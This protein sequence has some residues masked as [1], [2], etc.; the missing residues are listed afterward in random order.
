MKYNWKILVLE[1]N[2]IESK[3]LSLF[4]EEYFPKDSIA[5]AHSFHDASQYIKNHRFDLIFTDL[6]MPE[7]T[8]MDFIVD[9]VREDTRHK[10]TPVIVISGAHPDSFLTHTVQRITFDFL[11]KP[12]TAEE[13]HST[14]QKVDEYLKNHALK[15][16]SNP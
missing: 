1:D 14:I 12:F 10:D 7:K 2:P 11:F 6:H 13:L 9:V 8:G 4:L 15:K 16:T 3:F 5:I